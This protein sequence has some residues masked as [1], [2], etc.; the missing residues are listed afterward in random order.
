MIIKVAIVEDDDSYASITKSHLERFQSESKYRFAVSCFKDGLDFL[1]KK[2]AEFDIVF[3]DIELPYMNGLDVARKMRKYDS[4]AAL[5]F[6]TNMGQYAIN[7]YE[8]DALDYLVKPVEYF[9]FTVKLK[10]AI[11]NLRDRASECLLLSSTNGLVRIAVEEINYIEVQN[12][13]LIFHA[14][15]ATYEIRGTLSEYES[16]LEASGFSKCNHCYL[17][18][19]RYVVSM[20]EN[21]VKLTSG[22]L[23]QM[24][25]PKRKKFS[26]DFVSFFSKQK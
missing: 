19:L 15:N 14:D 21:F 2:P 25:R 18:N 17:V 23:L 12:H 7:G 10:K 22:E 11:K 5:I 1:E 16:K 3:M 4:H 13:T 8:V 24:S 26:E 9:N 20:D 6:I